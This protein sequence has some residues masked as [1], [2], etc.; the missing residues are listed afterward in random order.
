MQKKTPRITC[1]ENNF[2]DKWQQHVQAILCS[3]AIP[4]QKPLSN[5][6]VC[7]NESHTRIFYNIW[8]F[9]K[10]SRVVS[11]HA[12]RKA[13]MLHLSH[14]HHLQAERAYSAWTQH[15][16]SSALRLVH[17]HSRKDL[18]PRQMLLDSGPKWKIEGEPSRL[19]LT[20]THGSIACSCPHN[21]G[22]WLTV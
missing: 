3:W 7:T 2:R 13:N 4:P 12:W 19:P 17:N 21:A 10:L 14:P 15:W 22:A 18:D 11:I 16:S 6:F 8:M 20:F 1:N 5:K 9:Q